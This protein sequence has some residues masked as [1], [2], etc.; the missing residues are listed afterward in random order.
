MKTGLRTVARA[1][2]AR[3]QASAQQRGAALLMTLIFIAVI[4]RAAPPRGDSLALG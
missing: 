4:G 2:V 3:C 1:R